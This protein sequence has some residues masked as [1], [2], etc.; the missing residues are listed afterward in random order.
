MRYRAEYGV[1]VSGLPGS[2]AAGGLAGGLAALGAEL[3]PGLALV[4]EEVGLG[5]AL[6]GVTLVIT[7]EGKLDA[8]SFDGKVVGGVLARG[9]RTLIVAGAIEPGTECPA[10]AISLVERFGL[11][12]AW[13]D[14]EG[15]VAEAVEAALT[16]S[17]PEVRYWITPVFSAS[18]TA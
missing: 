1:D 6:D 8:T 12:R 17:V 11:E 18:A 14:P 4:A 9:V 16:G 15:C 13:A 10:P 7:G 2:G 5:R 3:V